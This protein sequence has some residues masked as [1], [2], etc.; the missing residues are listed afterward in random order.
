MII[1]ENSAAGAVEFN[2]LV[3]RTLRAT[4]QRLGVTVAD[5]ARAS[6]VSCSSIEAIERGSASTRAERHDIAVAVGWLSNYEVVKRMSSQP[7]AAE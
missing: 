3:A 4:R 5:L 2:Q 1:D 7:P 6:G